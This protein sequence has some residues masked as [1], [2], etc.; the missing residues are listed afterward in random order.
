MLLSPTARS[1][2]LQ[3]QVEGFMAERVIPSEQAHAEQLHRLGDPFAQTDVMA[4]LKAEARA[5]GLEPVHA[6]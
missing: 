3:E 1:R 6:R 5:A 4:S 2:A